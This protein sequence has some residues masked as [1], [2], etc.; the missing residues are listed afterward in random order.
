M[1]GYSFMFLATRGDSKCCVPLRFLHPCIFYK[2]ELKEAGVVT[3]FDS[4]V[5]ISG[6]SKTLD[7]IDYYL[8]FF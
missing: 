6:V 5:K 4:Q 3:L 2:R 1:S 8:I 7:K